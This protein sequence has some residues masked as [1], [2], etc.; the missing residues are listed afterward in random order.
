MHGGVPFQV[1]RIQGCRGRLH[2]DVLL[3]EW[4]NQEDTDE[5]V[6]NI[7][8]YEG[9]AA[10]PDHR[11]STST[12]SHSPL[13]KADL[14]NIY[15]SLNDGTAMHSAL[16]AHMPVVRLLNAQACESSNNAFMHVVCLAA[17][18]QVTAPECVTLGC[19]NNDTILRLSPIVL[20]SHGY[21]T[22]D[23]CVCYS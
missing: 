9:A 17:M 1:P 5:D 19:A 21:T 14:E 12:C 11:G 6:C 7:I 8:A 4:T 2:A 18:L 10:G 3:C 15:M 22:V 13:K 20:C 23:I 16:P